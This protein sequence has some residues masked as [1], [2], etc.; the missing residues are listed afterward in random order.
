MDG[1]KEIAKHNGF[2]N[3]LSKAA[4]EAAEF[5]QVLMRYQISPSDELKRDLLEEI[6][7]TLI[8]IEQVC[9]HMNFKKC[10][11]DEWKEGKINKTLNRI[12]NETT[13]RTK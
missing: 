1:I 4:E 7:D 10:D 6:A 5:I 2:K 11:I 9:L 12:E 3:S 13:R 8:T